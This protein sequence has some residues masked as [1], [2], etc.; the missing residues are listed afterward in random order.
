M[1]RR[2]L[3]TVALAVAAVA[4]NGLSAT[5]AA[6]GS[7]APCEFEQCPWGKIVCTATTLCDR[8]VLDC[9]WIDDMIICL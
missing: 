3:A 6:A 2:A 4:A 5:P 7:A 9:W 1:S 8:P